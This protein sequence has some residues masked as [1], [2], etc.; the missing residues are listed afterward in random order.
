MKNTYGKENMN[1]NL[2]NNM[3]KLRNTKGK[4]NMNINQIY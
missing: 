1:I 3:I 2:M 4:E